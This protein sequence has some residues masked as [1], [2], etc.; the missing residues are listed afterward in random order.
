MANYSSYG[1]RFAEQHIME[2]KAFSRELCGIDED[3]KDYFFNLPENELNQILRLYG[4]RFGKNAEQ[5]ARQTFRRWKTGTTQMSGLVA[6]RLFSLLPSRMPI[7][8][9]FELAEN[10]WCHFGPSSQNTFVIGPRTNLDSLVMTVA[11]KLDSVI[12]SYGIPENV[13]N[14]Y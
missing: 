1:N 9:K 5:Y 3:V 13:K 10:I 12:L 11:E 8:K 4:M 7:Q 6:Q 2:A 14:R